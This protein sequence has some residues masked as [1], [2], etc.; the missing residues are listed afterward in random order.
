M[1]TPRGPAASGRQ[2][3]ATLRQA[4]SREGNESRGT[5]AVM[6]LGAPRAQPD[7]PAPTP[8]EKLGALGMKF[9]TKADF[10]VAREN[11]A[12]HVH[13]TP[14][15]GSETLSQLTGA[16]VHLKGG[17]LSEGGLVQGP[18]TLERPG[19]HVERRAGARPDLLVG[20]Q[21]RPGRGP[22]C[23]RVRSARDGRDGERS[24]RGQDPG[25]AVVRRRGRSPRRGLGRRLP[26]LSGAAEGARPHL[27]PPVRRPTPGRRPGR[28]RLRDDRG[29]ARPR[30]HH[31]SHRW[32]WPDLGDLPDR[33]ADQAGRHG[34]RCRDGPGDPR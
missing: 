18:R 29:P 11:A 34:D 32:R 9:L 26:P 14:I 17:A 23:E 12:P 10:D 3:R 13:R 7:D 24:A 33:Q 4:P 25:D 21:P 5:F 6:K 16:H 2:W 20:R 15:F 31:R 8:D 19:A 27:R 28:R 22:R 30:P 1:L